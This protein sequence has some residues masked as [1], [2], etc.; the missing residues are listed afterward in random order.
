M[1]PVRVLSVRYLPNADPA[2]RRA[3]ALPSELPSLGF[4]TTDCD[5]AT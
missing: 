4:L 5:D 2:L 3:L 1:I